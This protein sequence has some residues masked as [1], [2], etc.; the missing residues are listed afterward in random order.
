MGLKPYELV[1]SGPRR[2]DWISSPGLLNFEGRCD[3]GAV[4]GRAGPGGT[5]SACRPLG[6]VAFKANPPSFYR[7]VILSS[8]YELFGFRWLSVVQKTAARQTGGLRIVRFARCV[9][10]SRAA[11]PPKI[12]MR[13]SLYEPPVG[14]K[15]YGLLFRRWQLTWHVRGSVCVTHVILRVTS[16]HSGYG[17]L[18]CL[19]RRRRRQQDHCLR[20]RWNK[21]ALSL[22]SF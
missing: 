3:Q 6:T 2:C 13:V 19:P 1:R 11:T 17:E 10:L 7:A 4:L 14:Q 21:R 12:L 5:H 22:K 18:Q 16:H 9:R 8:L 20:R 15:E